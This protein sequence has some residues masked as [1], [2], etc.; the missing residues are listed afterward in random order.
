MVMQSRIIVS[1]IEASPAVRW[2]PNVP[3]RPRHLSPCLSLKIDFYLIIFQ[4]AQLMANDGM[5]AIDNMTY[6]LM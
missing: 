3:V 6:V 1:D 4:S 2:I 5:W